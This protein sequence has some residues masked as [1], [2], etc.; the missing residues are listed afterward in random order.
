MV[1]GLLSDRSDLF[2]VV[3]S[4]DEGGLDF[5]YLAESFQL[6]GVEFVDLCWC[7]A[8]CVYTVVESWFDDG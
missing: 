2:V 1:D 3:G 7:E 8:E 5:E 4:L 6:K